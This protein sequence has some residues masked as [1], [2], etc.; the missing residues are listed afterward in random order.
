MT[1][2]SSLDGKLRQGEKR[3]FDSP[4]IKLKTV[5]E[6]QP[7]SSVWSTGHFLSDGQLLASPTNLNSCS[8]AC[9]CDF[10][11]KSLQEFPIMPHNGHL[12]YS[13]KNGKTW[14]KPVGTA[15]QSGCHKAGVSIMCRQHGACGG[16]SCQPLACSASLGGP[17]MQ[18]ATTQTAHMWVSAWPRPLRVA[19]T[20][21]CVCFASSLG[22]HISATVVR[23]ARRAGGFC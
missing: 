5:T 13:K 1:S 12:S 6:Q 20:A 7:E 19:V 9:R 8:W 18:L 11:R 16:K 17:R 2:V 4:R 3:Y 10:L 21:S 23:T 14:V 22:C 15:Q